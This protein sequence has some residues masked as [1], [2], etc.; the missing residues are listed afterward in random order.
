MSLPERRRKQ[1]QQI[2]GWPR[3][4]TVGRFREAAQSTLLFPL[5]RSGYTLEVRGRENLRG[6]KQPCLIVSNH[7]MHLDWSMV[8]RALPRSFR[9]RT[10]VAA[11]ATDIFGNRWRAFT[12]KL[13]GNAFAFEKG[14]SGVR[15]S[16][17]QTQALLDSGWNV[18]IFPEGKLTVCGPLQP[19][20]SGIGW[21]AARS[22]AEI[23]P[24]RVDVLRPGLF[25][26]ARFPRFRGRA[27]V[28]IGKPLV[29]ERGAAHDDSAR[30]LEQ[31]VRDA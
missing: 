23:V 25:E 12:G 21:I 3:W 9:R 30:R 31:A 22:E 29:I 1:P 5:I 7:N 2:S 14:G 20:K 15:E 11:A 24:M 17:E 13:L 19:F 10:M 4:G 26:G 8:L 16:L 28:S 18:L 6:V 27:R